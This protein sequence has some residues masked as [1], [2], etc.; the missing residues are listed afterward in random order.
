MKLTAD[1]EKI[2]NSP[3]FDNR[4]L[5]ISKTCEEEP[6]QTMRVYTAVVLLHASKGSGVTV[7]EIVAFV[8]SNLVLVDRIIESSLSRTK[9]IATLIQ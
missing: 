6:H 5:L 1:G 2:V 7:E 8:N 9:T 4:I 3:D